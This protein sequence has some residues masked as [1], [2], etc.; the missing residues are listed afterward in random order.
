[1]VNRPIWPNGLI[2]A[3]TDFLPITSFEMIFAFLLI[4]YCNFLKTTV[5]TKLIPLIQT[6]PTTFIKTKPNNLNII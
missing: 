3:L 1:M 4:F 2:I 6:K 5:H